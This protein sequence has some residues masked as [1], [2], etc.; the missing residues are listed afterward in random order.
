MLCDHLKCPIAHMVANLHSGNHYL[1]LGILSY[2]WCVFW[3]VRQRKFCRGEAAVLTM[4]HFLVSVPESCRN[5]HS[6]GHDQCSSLDSEFR[7]QCLLSIRSLCQPVLMKLFLKVHI[8]YN[9]PFW[10]ESRGLGFS[11]KDLVQT[12]SV[13]S[14]MHTLH[15]GLSVSSEVWDQPQMHLERGTPFVV[16]IIAFLYSSF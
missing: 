9:N 4:Q 13:V 8:Y 14:A 16:M 5:L 6:I 15:I 11:W 10:Y 12:M 7:S 3:Q 1:Q 2:L